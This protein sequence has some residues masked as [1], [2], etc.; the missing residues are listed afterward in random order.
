MFGEWIFQHIVDSMDLRTR[1]T[2]E[3]EDEA[4]STKLTKSWFWPDTK[5]WKRSSHVSFFEFEQL[6]GEKDTFLWGR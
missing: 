6:I 5:P 1:P 3:S 4:N 2:V